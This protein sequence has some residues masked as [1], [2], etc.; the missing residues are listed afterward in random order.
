[1]KEI[2]KNEPDTDI[3]DLLMVTFYGTQFFKS[4]EGTEV[5]YGT[6]LLQPIIRLI[7]TS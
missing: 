6:R 4:L 5:R 3:L 7:D 1:M 2:S